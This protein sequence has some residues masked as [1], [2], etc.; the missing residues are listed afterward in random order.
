[1]DQEIAKLQ[2]RPAQ[3]DQAASRNSQTAALLRTEAQT[4]IRQ[5]LAQ[6]SNI[7][8]E[9]EIVKKARQEVAAIGLHAQKQGISADRIRT[10][11]K[12]ATYDPG[13]LDKLV[14]DQ[15]GLYAQAD[16]ILL[17]ANTLDPHGKK[18]EFQ[19]TLRPS[20]TPITRPHGQIKGSRGK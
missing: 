14:R 18:A 7:Q 12:P 5:A 2:A 13:K 15:Q 11:I 9:W 4:L 3:Q 20:S 10:A 19:S 1:L 16:R 8:A 6:E 17:R